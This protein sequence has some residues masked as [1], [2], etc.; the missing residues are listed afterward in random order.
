MDRAQWSKR[1]N[2]PMSQCSNVPMPGTFSEI[3]QKG[4]SIKNV[5][6]VL[7][8]CTRWKKIVTSNLIGASACPLASGNVR[9]RWKGSWLLNLALFQLCYRWNKA[10]QTIILP[11][12]LHLALTPFSSLSSSNALDEKKDNLPWSLAPAPERTWACSR[13]HEARRPASQHIP[14][15][16]RLAAE[17][18]TSPKSPGKFI[19][20][21]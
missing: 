5:I 8:S 17:T 2:V 10:R 15:G 19:R 1:P 6:I 13:H 16:P 4:S 20:F 14:S 7:T 3:L 12:I 11:W 9:T 18:G 21:A